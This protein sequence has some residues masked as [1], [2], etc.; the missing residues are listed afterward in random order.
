MPARALGDRHNPGRLELTLNDEE[1]RTGTG[2]EEFGA[3]ALK[4]RYALEARTPVRQL[5]DQ[6]RG[7]AAALRERPRLGKLSAVAAGADSSLSTSHKNS[8]CT[9]AHWLHSRR[10]PFPIHF[11]HLKGVY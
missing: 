8:T 10:P 11:Y 1:V 2:R 3:G 9:S 6:R 4:V 7:M 5:G